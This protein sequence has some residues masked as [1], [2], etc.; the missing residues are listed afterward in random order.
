VLSCQEIGKQSGL[1]MRQLERLFKHQLHTTPAAFYMQRRL[2]RSNHLLEQSTLT[3]TQIAAACGF[4]SASYFSQCYQKNYGLSPR[5]E[6][7]KIRQPANQ[8]L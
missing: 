8:P 2:E 7:G 6:R 3:V 4:N 1:S 5:E